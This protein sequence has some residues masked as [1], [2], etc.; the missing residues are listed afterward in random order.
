MKIDPRHSKY[1]ADR[2]VAAMFNEQEISHCEILLRRLRF[3]E[4]QINSSTSAE[5]N[6]GAVF[7]RAEAS[8]LVW[9]LKDVGYLSEVDRQPVSRNETR[10]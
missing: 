8:A 10:R 2:N 7:A 1:H 5:G 9:T 4:H 6:G 3:L